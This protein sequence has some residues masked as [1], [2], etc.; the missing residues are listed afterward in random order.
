MEEHILICEDS[1]EGIF[2]AVYC[3]YEKHYKPENTAIQI[4][5]EGN[6]RLF[7]VYEKIENDREKSKKVIRTLQ[8]RF[9][10]EGFYM[11]CLALAS[12]DEGKGTAV[13]RTIAK[14]LRLSR[15]DTVFNRH[16]DADVQRVQ[17]LKYN[18]WHEMHQL[19]GFVRFRV[20]KSGILFSE[21]QPKNHVI[22]FLAD[23]F[24]DRFPAEHFLIYDVGRALF[25]VHEAGKPWFLAQNACFKRE[26]MEE[27]EEEGIYQELFRHFCHKI[28]VEARENGRL[29]RGM[30]PL[31]FRPYM[32]EFGKADSS[33]GHSF[34]EQ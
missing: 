11:I 29:Q 7:A 15:P 16:A 27:C 22:S 28:A 23:H 32:T 26:D 1:L 2:T 34:R 4:T 6:L 9:G 5:E 20:L 12:T 14:G 31:R 17:K 21:I 33:V 10:E 13:Y 8:R 30:L 24:A 19:I 25:A 18:A 3:A